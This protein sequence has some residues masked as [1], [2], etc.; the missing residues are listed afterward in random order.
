M[1]LVKLPSISDYWST[2][3]I[4]QQPFPRTVMTRNRFELLLQYLHF[5]DNYN[6]NPNDR[7]GKIR[8][9]VNLLND[10]FKAYY[11]PKPW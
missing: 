11:A 7:I 4:F 9:L 2:D 8:Y 5:A 6:L 10:K 1:G 3:D